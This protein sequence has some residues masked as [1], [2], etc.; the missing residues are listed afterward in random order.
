MR[1]TVER[2]LISCIRLH[3]SRKDLGKVVEVSRQHICTPVTTF[4]ADLSVVFMTGGGGRWYIFVLL[5]DTPACILRY[6]T[7]P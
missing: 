6:W 7:R 5:T 3:V 2:G 4:G 1:Q